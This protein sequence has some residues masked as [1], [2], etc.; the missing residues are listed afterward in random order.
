[1]PNELIVFLATALGSGILVGLILKLS[2]FNSW[3]DHTN[4]RKVHSGDIPRLGGIGFSLV[5]V[6]TAGILVFL[7][8][9]GDAP[10]RFLPCLAGIC[11]IAAAGVWDDFHPIRPLVKFLIQL[12]AALCV[13]IPGYAFDRLLFFNEALFAGIPWL[14]QGI[15]ISIT[16]LWI[17]GITNAINLIDGIDALAGGVSAI[18]AL[19]FA[20][21]FSFYGETPA[22]ELICIAMAGAIT[23]F[24]VFNA[25]FPKAKIFMG[26]GG[27]QFLGFTL[28]LLPLMEEHRT[29][30]ALPALYAVTLLVI[31]IFDTI[32]AVWRRVRDKQKISA[33]DRSHV[34][35]KLMNLGLSVWQIDA[36]LIG[37][38]SIISVLVFI[39]LKMPGVLSL[40]FLGM[41]F[42][43]A[44]AFFAVIH[45]ANRK[46]PPEK[47]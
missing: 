11:I 23:G 42:L 35:H 1:M 9:K 2:R 3:Y 41:S 31:P 28:A 30:A 32:A 14:N 4:E 36:V 27:S 43:L 45:F 21:I 10:F 29:S 39:S 46:L 44:L 7:F 13:V 34:H 15:T 33:P 26:D 37:L 19:T 24:L 8:R 17:I 38:Q 40:V 25:P 5:F 20:L 22:A 6:V 47:R 18:I 16:I 12:A